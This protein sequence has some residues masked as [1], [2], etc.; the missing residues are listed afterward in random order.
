MLKEKPI[1]PNR[2]KDR[3]SSDCISI[4]L[5]TRESNRYTWLIAQFRELS[6]LSDILFN[7]AVSAGLGTRDSHLGFLLA[8]SPCFND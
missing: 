6:I 7:G 4:E 5:S 1:M 3:L 2:L 8:S